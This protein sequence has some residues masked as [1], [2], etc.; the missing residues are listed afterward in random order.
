MLLPAEH[1]FGL[2]HPPAHPVV[3]RKHMAQVSIARS[4][5]LDVGAPARPKLDVD[6]NPR[7]AMLFFGMLGCALFF[8][9]YSVYADITDTGVR[10]NRGCPFCSSASRCS[11][12]SASSS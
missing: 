10:A 6:V 8:V 9:A 7:T 5:S 4:P 12:R 2:L 1:G 3:A 11:L